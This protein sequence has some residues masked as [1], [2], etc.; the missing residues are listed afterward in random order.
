MAVILQLGAGEW[1]KHSIRQIQAIGHK[2]YAVDKNPNAPAFAIAEGHA[3]IDLVDVDSITDYAREIR[4]GAILAANEA[5][6]LAA[7]HAC[8]RLGLPGLHPDTAIKA[9]DKGKMRT[10]WESTGL[11]QPNFLI[12]NSMNRYNFLRNVSLRVDIVVKVSSS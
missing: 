11:S 12:V 7:A 3:P 9:L 2:V 1:M 5:G 8:Q 6:V 10:A 4:A